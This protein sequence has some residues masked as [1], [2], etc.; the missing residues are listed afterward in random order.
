MASTTPNLKSNTAELDAVLKILKNKAAGSIQL[1]ELTNPGVA[2]DLLPNKQ[3]IDGEGNRV[4]GAMPRSSRTFSGG[5]LVPL[6]G[7]VEATGTG[8]TLG[9]KTKTQPTSGNYI[10]VTGQGKVGV[11]AIKETATAGYCEEATRTVIS[12]NMTDSQVATAYYPF[13]SSVVNTAEGDATSSDIVNGKFAYVK[14]QKVKGSLKNQLAYAWNPT[15]LSTAN[16]PSYSLY[17][18]FTSNNSSYNYLSIYSTNI[19]GTIC[20]ALAY[21][22][23]SSSNTIKVWD[24]KNGWANGA[25][26]LVC[27][28]G[29]DDFMSENFLKVLQYYMTLQK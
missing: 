15:K 7:S 18:N 10:T 1:P 5:E 24:S 17:V 6:A 27:F 25:Y 19:Q 9:T 16:N 20:N 28:K 2:E 3:L 11:N 12:S 14:G 4:E 13:S 29:G 23:G 22:I 26:Q 21:G 8:I